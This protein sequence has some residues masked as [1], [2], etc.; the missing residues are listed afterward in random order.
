MAPFDGFAPSDGVSSETTSNTRNGSTCTAPVTHCT[1]STLAPASAATP[2]EIYDGGFESGKA[3]GVCI[4]IANGTAGQVGLVRAWA[5]N[6]IRH[7]VKEGEDPFLIAWYLGDS[8]QSLALLSSGEVDMALTYV[9]AA[10]VQLLQSGDASAR[11]YV[12][13]DRFAL[14]G[15]VCNP[16]GL[17]ETDC[18]YT[19]FSKIA[20]RG[21]ADV[22]RPPHPDVR[23][24]T[25]FLSRCDKSAT[26]IKESQ[27]FLSIGQLPWGHDYSRWYHQYIRFPRE[28][29]LAAAALSEYTL[30]DYGAWLSAPTSVHSQLK[31]FKLGSDAADDVLINPAHLLFRGTGA[32][33]VVEKAR[34]ALC[35]EFYGWVVDPE[36]G[37][38]VTLGFRK[39]GCV[40][41]TKAP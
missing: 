14:V 33:R 20:A 34:D 5:D 4:R 31:M 18:I 27:I 16:A 13:R 30:I 19:M 7:M 2:Y 24:A 1:L 26:N 22:R 9:P 12:F 41:Y 40:L 21:D 3:R 15:P 37:L 11:T 28:A 23:P 8:T 25:R 35:K 10:E 17:Q 38:Q 39:E 36:G 29:L 6:F 32:A